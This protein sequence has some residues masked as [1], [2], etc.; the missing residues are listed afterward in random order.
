MQ[1][2]FFFGMSNSLINPMIYGAFHLWRPSSG[3][4]GGG[5]GNTTTYSCASSRRRPNNNRTNLNNSSFNLVRNREELVAKVH[6]LLHSGKKSLFLSLFIFSE[7]RPQLR[8][9]LDCS[10][11]HPPPQL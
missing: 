11:L 6:H 8:Q 7:R 10:Y 2:I 3:G 9:L 1:N 5:S 4:S